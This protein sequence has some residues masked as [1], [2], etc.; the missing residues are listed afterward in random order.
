MLKNWSVPLSRSAAPPILAFAPETNVA[1]LLFVRSLELCASSAV[2]DVS[3]NLQYDARFWLSALAEAVNTPFM[4]YIPEPEFHSVVTSVELRVLFHI[5]TSS[6]IPRN[7]SAPAFAEPRKK[8]AVELNMVA[9]VASDTQ[10]TR[11]PSL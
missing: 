9:G 4:K 1:P 10:D 11:V 3:S 6:K 5:P 8:S 7:G 2:P